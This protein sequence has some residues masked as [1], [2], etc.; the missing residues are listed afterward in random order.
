MLPYWKVKRV[1]SVDRPLLEVRCSR[2]ECGRAFW[3]PLGWRTAIRKGTII[4][5]S[6][7]WC[8]RTFQLP[9]GKVPH[10]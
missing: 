4:G 9:P 2:K 6:C 3:V 8:S 10:A 7:P 1:D 5:R